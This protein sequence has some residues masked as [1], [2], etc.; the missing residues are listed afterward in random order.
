MSEVTRDSQ[1]RTRLAAEDE[2]APSLDA[3]P[4]MDARTALTR[5]LAEYLIGLESPG[6]DGRMAFLR[7]AFDVWPEPEA[8]PR[9]P[10]ALVYSA[11]RMR[12]DS[13]SMTPRVFDV[14][15]RPPAPSPLLDP[16]ASLSLAPRRKALKQA[17]E[18]VLQVTVNIEVTDKNMRPMIAGMLERALTPDPSRYNLVLELPHYHGARASYELLESVYVDSAEVALRN[19]PAV[20][21][22][23]E[24]RAPLLSVIE[25]A[26]ASPRVTSAVGQGVVIRESGGTKRLM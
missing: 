13:A 25:V 2:W 20:L 21:F 11:E 12:Y 8:V 22:V 10:S 3:D 14:A 7:V 5:G 18:C 17:C 9:Y 4:D 16:L 19:Q 23:L 1:V 6:A 24:A 15:Q 26:S